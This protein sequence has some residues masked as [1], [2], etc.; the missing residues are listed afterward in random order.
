MPHSERNYFNSIKDQLKNNIMNSQFF[1]PYTRI[2]SIHELNGIVKQDNPFQ[3][4]IRKFDIF[5]NERLTVLQE[6]VQEIKESP[7]NVTEW[8]QDTTKLSL[9]QRKLDK[10]S[11][12][13]ILNVTF[14]DYIRENYDKLFW[15][16]DQLKN[17]TPNI[18]WD[19]IF[20]GFF[21]RTNI[22]EKVLVMD[23]NFA[24]NINEIIKQIDKR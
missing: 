18:N 19:K 2:N 3:R 11:S 4:E 22:T 20:M 10:I 7:L 16:V 13:I 21:G 17:A 6:I 12:N 14:Q 8:D 9:I 24:N 5:S 15:S 1:S 23:S